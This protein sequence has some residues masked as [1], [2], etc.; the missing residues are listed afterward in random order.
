MFSCGLS[1]RCLLV[2]VQILHSPHLGSYPHAAEP[3]RKKLD[4]LL[5]VAQLQAL[6]RIL[7]EKSASRRVAASEDQHYVMQ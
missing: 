6:H 4:S 3:R 5:L 7:P 1:S 2:E